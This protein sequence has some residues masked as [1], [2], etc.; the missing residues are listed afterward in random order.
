MVVSSVVCC[1]LYSV[2]L[3][4]RLC[5]VSDPLIHLFHIIRNTLIVHLLSYFGFFIGKAGRN[6]FCIVE[7]IL[8]FIQLESISSRLAILRQLEAPLFIIVFLT[9]EGNLTV[10]Q[11]K[12]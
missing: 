6:R 7:C 5:I 4:K 11:W 3:V 8:L 2:K 1:S 10:S 9:T 12:C